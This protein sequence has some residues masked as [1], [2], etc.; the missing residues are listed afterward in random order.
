MEKM[1]II[2]KNLKIV[3]FFVFKEY[4][5][6]LKVKKKYIFCFRHFFSF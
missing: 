1:D 5:F 6:V 4:N 3:L 2:I